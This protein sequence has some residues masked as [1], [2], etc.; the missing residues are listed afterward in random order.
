MTSD[1][2]SIRNY[3]EQVVFRRVATSAAEYPHLADDGEALA[4][5]ACVA[6]N[7]LPPKYIRNQVDM[8]FFMSS[9]D[10]AKIEAA[11]DAAVTFAFRFMA[12]RATAPERK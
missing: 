2:D 1:F 4:D 5:I 9:E 6:L 12:A 7:R 3:Y 8:N 10:R 11:V